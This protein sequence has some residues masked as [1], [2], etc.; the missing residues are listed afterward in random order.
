MLDIELLGILKIMCEVMKDHQEG[1]KFDP[2][3]IEPTSAVNCRTHTG[4]DSRL[5][6][7]GVINNNP[8][9]SD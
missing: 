7:M 3:M 1:R 2:Q 8:N 4:D 9:I 6:G 5:D